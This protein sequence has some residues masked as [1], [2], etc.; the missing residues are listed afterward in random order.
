MGRLNGGFQLKRPWLSKSRGV[1]EDTVRLVN[2]GLVPLARVM[3]VQGD[4]HTHSVLLFITRGPARVA[5]QHQR[6]QPGGLGLIRQQ[7][8]HQV[9]QINRLPCQFTAVLVV[10]GQAKGGVDGLQH[11]V[12]AIGQ[13]TRLGGFQSNAGQPDFG[14]GAH[15]ALRHGAGAHQKGGCNFVGLNAQHGLHHQGAA[16]RRI[17]GRVGAGKH[18]LQALIGYDPSRRCFG[19]LVRQEHGDGRVLFNLSVAVVLKQVSAGSRH[20]PGLGGLRHTALR[21]VCQ[22]SGEGFCQGVFGRCNVPELVGQVSQNSP[23]G[24]SGR[25]GRG[26]PGDIICR[27]CSRVGHSIRPRACRAAVA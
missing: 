8:G 22:R 20:Q 10:P 2:P 6:Q 7:R 19:G 24:S 17:D 27:S 16:H 26:L 1:P 15:E 21:P 25:A 23:V 5:E 11:V 13:V 9:S 3:G 14:F 12:Q 18:E 4:E